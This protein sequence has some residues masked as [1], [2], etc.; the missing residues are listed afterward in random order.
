MHPSRPWKKYY[1]LAGWRKHTQPAVLARDPL[2]KLM[3][4]PL[5]AQHGGDASE[6]ADHIKDHKG[7]LNL[8]FDMSNLQ[9]VCKPCHDRKTGLTRGGAKVHADHCGMRKDWGVCTCEVNDASTPV[10]P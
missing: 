6:V 10:L 8:F 4:T 3:I 2:C 9:G 5:C 1:D 7:D